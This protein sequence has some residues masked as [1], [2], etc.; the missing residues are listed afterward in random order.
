M[1]WLMGW[2]WEFVP[3]EDNWKAS[4]LGVEQWV[5]SAHPAACCAVKSGHLYL[6]LEALEW[7]IICDSVI[8]RE[9]SSGAD[10][11]ALEMDTL[12]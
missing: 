1:C 7:I 9:F 10:L 11:T 8:S 3:R 6:P 5:G 4:W 2:Q 12:T